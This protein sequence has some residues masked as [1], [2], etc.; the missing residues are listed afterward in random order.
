MRDRLDKFMAI[1]TFIAIADS[2][3]FTA[4]SKTLGISVATATKTIARLEKQM[5]VRLLHRNTRK[6]SLTTEGREFYQHCTRILTELEEAEGLIH[7]GT[8]N[9]VGT[10]RVVATPSFGRLMLVPALPTFFERYPQIK[11]ELDARNEPIDVIGEG[12]DC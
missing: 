1:N 5:S 12:Y 3:S 2:G 6:V 9:P 10:I 8:T 11:I 7:A 4:A